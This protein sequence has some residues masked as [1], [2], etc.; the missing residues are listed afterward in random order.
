MDDVWSKPKLRDFNLDVTN[1]DEAY[2]VQTDLPGLTKE[3]IDLTIDNGILTIA[4]ERKRESTKGEMCI[5]ERQFGRF[6]RSVKLPDLEEGDCTA[7]LKNGVLT[8]TIEKPQK[9]KRKKL[10]ILEEA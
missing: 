7:S 1:T 4:C 2:I 6:E 3:E 5:Q 9:A 10:T 8:V